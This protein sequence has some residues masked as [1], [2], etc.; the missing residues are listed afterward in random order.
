MAAAPAGEGGL[1][2]VCA[3]GT[4]ELKPVSI[5]RGPAEQATEKNVLA[6]EKSRS[7]RRES[8]EESAARR[9]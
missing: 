6:G 4:D 9:M 5:I 3:S 8:R 1:P 7:E 2:K